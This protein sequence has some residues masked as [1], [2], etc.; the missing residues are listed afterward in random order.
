MNIQFEKSSGG[1]KDQMRWEDFLNPDVVQPTIAMASI[2]IAAFEILKDTLIN[3]VREFSSFTHQYRDDDP[4]VEAKYNSDV[5]SLNK[6]VVYASL[7]WLTSMQAIDNNDV[8][9]FERVKTCR[10][11]LAHELPRIVSTGRLPLDFVDCLKEMIALLQKVETWWIINF[12]I[13][14]NP[15]L[16]DKEIIETGIIPGPVFWLQLMSEVAL[17]SKKYYEGLKEN[18]DGTASD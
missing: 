16:D 14:T 9:T 4:A 7:S 8:A 1:N 13:P 15:D 18:A 5:L 10:N 17:G 3:R 2:Y 11:E 6:S 12:E